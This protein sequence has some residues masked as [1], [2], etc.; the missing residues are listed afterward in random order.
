M[1]AK[2]TIDPSSHH[3]SPSKTTNLQRLLPSQHPPHPFNRTLSPHHPCRIVK[4][5]HPT[6]QTLAAQNWGALCRRLQTSCLS[7]VLEHAYAASADART[8]TF[9]AYCALFSAMRQG[10]QHHT[11]QKSATQP[12]AQDSTCT[13]PPIPFFCVELQ[14]QHEQNT[15]AAFSQT[16]RKGARQFRITILHVPE[17][18]L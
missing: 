3:A 6:L 5:S 8:A 10:K 14:Q 18:N 9:C 1:C 12:A 11:V 2:S 7:H 13:A 4:P 17:H 16:E 15:P